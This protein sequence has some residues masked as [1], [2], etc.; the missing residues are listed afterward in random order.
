MLRSTGARVGEVLRINR[1]CINWETGDVM[2][3]SEKKRTTNSYRIL[4][5]DEEC[6][7]HLQKYLSTRIDNNPSAIY[8]N[9]VRD[10]NGI[11]RCELFAQFWR[12]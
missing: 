8:R 2:V 1:F 6:R 7:Y 3:Q 12:Q 11:V 9:W 5:L 4:Y 10:S